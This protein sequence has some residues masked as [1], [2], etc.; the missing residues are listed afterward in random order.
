LDKLNFRNEKGFKRRK[1]N[2]LHKKHT[3]KMNNDLYKRQSTI[4]HTVGSDIW[5]GNS[6]TRGLSKVSM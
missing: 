4:H 1:E 3:L 2:E 5:P 6:V